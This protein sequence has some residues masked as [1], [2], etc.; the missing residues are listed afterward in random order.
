MSSDG[1]IS[2][3]WCDISSEGPWQVDGEDQSTGPSVQPERRSVNNPA[4]TGRLIGFLDPLGILPAKEHLLPQ[5]FH[6]PL[7]NAAL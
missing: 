2:G 1:A 3:G 7:L 4:L 5:E 6:F